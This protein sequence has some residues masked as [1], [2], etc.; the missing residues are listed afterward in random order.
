MKA[1]YCTK[2][3]EL[4]DPDSGK[5]GAV[6]VLD[7]PEPETG[8]E[9]V[10]IKV[11]YCGICGSD[12]HT[13]AGIFNTPAPFP[14]GHELSGVIVEVGK[15]ATVNG[16]K[17]GD[18][19]SGN[20]RKVCGTCY[21][22][23]NAQEQFCHVGGP[24]VGGMAEYVCW[25]EKQVVKLPESVSLL[26]GSLLEPVS[27][28]VRAM[29]KSN[30]K[31]GQN[32]VVSG[33][34]PIG[35]LTLQAVNMFGAANLTLLEPNPQRRE[36]AKR[37]GAKYVFDPAKDDVMAAAAEIT[38]GRGYD[39]LFEVSGVPSAAKSM[40]GL[41]ARR[42]GLVYV[43]QYPRDFD[44]P[45]NAYGQLY[46]KEVSVTGIFVSPYTFSRTA[47]VIE[48][49]DLDAFTQSVINIGDVKQAFETHLSGKYPKVV[50]KCDPDLE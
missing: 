18:R 49:F 23:T 47:Q 44:M 5:R 20:F 10:K 35:L 13:V 31:F 27:I 50:V 41:A 16:L 33:G 15:N 32:V 40:F 29:D 37:Y 17:A 9:E 43:A 45:V 6:D 36:L 8:P 24:P 28:A 25:H 39:V 19:V 46:E 3:G 4:H 11:A 42:A 30:I 7:M 26:T 21:D 48:R 38:G 1:V 14:L 12:P 34:G 22:C 2:V